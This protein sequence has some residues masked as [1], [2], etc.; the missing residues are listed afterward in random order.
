[1][2]KKWTRAEEQFLETHYRD[3]TDEDL[4]ERL[5][6]TKRTVALKLRKLGLERSEKASDR[7]KDEDLTGKRTFIRGSDEE[8]KPADCP[9]A[10]GECDHASRA[11]DCP[12]R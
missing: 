1:M 3:L 5:G 2:A 9:G 8:V 4:A 12:I 6:V 7:V 11:D 10:E